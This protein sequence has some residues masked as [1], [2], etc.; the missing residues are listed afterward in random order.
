M[1]ELAQYVAAFAAVTGA[2][3]WLTVRFLRR[4]RSCG[5]CGRC[6]RALGGSGGGGSCQGKGVRSDG[7]R[8]LQ[9]KP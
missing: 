3:A 4:R 7:L 2:A 1:T 9:G 8:I 6:E 5:N